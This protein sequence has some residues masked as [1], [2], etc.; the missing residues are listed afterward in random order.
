ME[1]IQYNDQLL[2]LLSRENTW[3]WTVHPNDQKVN[4][5][6]G[7]KQGFL[8]YVGGNNRA[9]LLKLAKELKNKVGLYCFELRPAK[10]LKAD[11][12]WELKIEGLPIYAI[13]C[14]SKLDEPEEFDWTP[15]IV[16][17]LL[18]MPQNQFC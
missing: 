11:C 7:K 18:L 4:K 10:H 17:Q 8:T 14:I 2:I 6:L 12:K 1:K 16:K 5:L 13:D 15:E 3:G 9:K